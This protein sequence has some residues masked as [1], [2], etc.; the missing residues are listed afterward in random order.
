VDEHDDVAT[1]VGDPSHT[2]APG[3]V[4]WL[5]DRIKSVRMRLR[6][7]LSTASTQTQSTMRGPDAGR[8]GRPCSGSAASPPKPISD[9]SPIDSAMNEGSPR[10]EGGSSRRLP[11][12]SR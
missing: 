8:Y 6:E 1:G 7:K 2:F 10:L 4:G 9:D 11:S 12:K 3:H 5:G